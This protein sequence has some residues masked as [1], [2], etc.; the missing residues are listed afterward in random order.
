MPLIIGYKPCTDFH[1]LSMGRS[2]KALFAC[3]HLATHKRCH[4]LWL[5]FDPC[6]WWR[7]LDKQACR[8]D[9]GR[10]GSVMRALQ[11][12]GSSCRHVCMQVLP[13]ILQHRSGRVLS[14]FWHVSQGQEEGRQQPVL[15]TSNQTA[16]WNENMSAC[17]TKP[18]MTAAYTVFT[19]SH[20]VNYSICH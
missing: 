7:L 16:V 13:Q 6:A 8:G 12:V 14:G 17:K 11:G 19:I 18:W 2:R 9:S 1:W 20:W 4:D 10:G 15:S 5:W 3:S